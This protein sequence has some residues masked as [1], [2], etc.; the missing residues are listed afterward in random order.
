M[1]RVR[2]RI[3]PRQGLP[4]R[5]PDLQATRQRGHRH[6]ALRQ[7]RPGRLR[8]RLGRRFVLPQG[9][10]H[11]ARGG[12]HERLGPRGAAAR[13]A[14]VRRRG[15]DRRRPRLSRPCARW[16]ASAR[17]TSPRTS[18]T[19]TTPS[20]TGSRPTERRRSSSA[21]RRSPSSGTSSRTSAPP[22]CASGSRTLRRALLVMHS[23]TDNTVGIANASEI[24]RT[25]GTRAASSPSRAPTTCS[26]A[27]TRPR[28]RPASSAPGPTPTC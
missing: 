20:S 10:R 4:G 5:E 9:R 23:P 19:T 15:R 6:A 22:I 17:R 7:P 25:A 24:F 11:R 13:R 21:A 28:G 8:R 26:P 12:V 27:R 2:P 18:S 16:P 14:L 3:H 1:G